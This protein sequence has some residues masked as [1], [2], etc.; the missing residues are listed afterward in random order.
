MA[1]WAAMQEQPKQRPQI[2]EKTGLTYA[3]DTHFPLGRTHQEMQRAE[4][5]MG[6][7]LHPMEPTFLDLTSSFNY[8]AFSAMRFRGIFP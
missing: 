8:H 5:A 7:M 2:I 3:W 6:E 1:A 4:R